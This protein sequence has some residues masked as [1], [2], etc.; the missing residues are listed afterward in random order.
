MMTACMVFS[1]LPFQLQATGEAHAIPTAHGNSVPALAETTAMVARLNEIRE[2]NLSAMGK[3]DK[4]QLRN[5]V[6][7]LKSDLRAAG[8]G[9]YL[10]VGAI[11]LIALLLIL[12]L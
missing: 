2:M 3:A 1:L 11:I 8:E 12:L 4:K 6:K 7:A 5:E 10:S 9:V